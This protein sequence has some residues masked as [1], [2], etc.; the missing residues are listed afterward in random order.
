MRYLTTNHTMKKGFS[1]FLLIVFSFSLFAQS[2]DQLIE[3]SQS[4]IEKNHWERAYRNLNELIDSYEDEMTYLQ[5][6]KVYNS[7]GYLNL[8]FM[9]PEEAELD[10][11]RAL[12]YHEEAG[13]PNEEAYAEALINTSMLYLEQVEFDLSRDY[14]KKALDILEKKDEYYV[15]YLI[16]RTKLARIYEEAGSYTL[17]LSIYDESYDKL[18]A[19]GN[20]LSPDFADIC[21]HKGRILTLTGNPIEGERFI[22]LS[23]TIYESLGT[24]YNVQRA[25]SLE[26]LALF[27][28]QMG[29][30]DE[31]ENLLLEVLA[32]KRSIPDEADILI[33]ETLNDLGVLYNQL[34]RFTKAEKMFSEVIKESEE[35]VGV[36]HPFY[37]TAKNNLGMLALSRGNYS[38]AKVILEEALQLY[39]ERFGPSHPYYANTLNNL[40][41]TARKLGNIDQAESYY[42]EVLKIDLKLFGEDHPNYATTL[43][44]IGI[45]LSASDREEGAGEFYEKALKIRKIALGVNHPSYGSALD[46]LG[47]HY[48]AVNELALAEES[49]RESIGIQ[50]NLIQ[51]LFPIMS[52]QEREQFYFQVR[53]KVERYHFIASQLLDENQDLAKHIFDFQ[54]KTKT[55][56]FNS[57]DKVRDIVADSKDEVLKERYKKWLSDKSLLASYYQMG[58]DELADLHINLEQVESDIESQELFLSQN[59]EAFEEALPHK[60]L[61]SEAIQKAVIDG[62]AVV[63]IIQV[64]EFGPLLKGRENI[65]GFTDNSS[66]LAIILDGEK[67]QHTFL[68]EKNKVDQEHLFASQNAQD[69][70]AQYW[71]PIIS[72]TKGAGWLRVVPDGL[73]HKVNPNQYQINKRTFVIDEQYV[74]Y[75][76]S[77]H[78]VVRSNKESFN[79]KFYHI[80]NP[81]LDA[82]RFS[83]LSEDSLTEEP[84]IESI[85]SHWKT[86]TY[87][88]ED[89]NEFRL[90]SAYNPT[91][92]HVSAPIFLESSKTFIE[93]KTAL[94]DASFNSGIFLSGVS[95][96]YK[97]YQKSIPSIPENDGVLTVSEIMKLE[98]ERTR[99]VF[100]SSV[101]LE[102]AIIEG[103]DG[104]FGLIRA[105]SVAGARN[106]ITSI[107][108]VNETE[109]REFIEIFYQ[110]FKET[111]QIEASFRHA[112]LE[113]KERYNNPEIW[114]AFI[115][116]GSRL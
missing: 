97:K 98:L 18:I 24:N 66:Y 94:S 23:S 43:L 42:Y 81:D 110:R 35:N 90:R 99:L 38:E 32:L 95:D 104:F 84:S 83:Q 21:S 7:L 74:S 17:A 82:F 100:L 1:L 101:E 69:S 60:N 46:Y 64:R 103:G 48:L 34:G 13:I 63:E 50:L 59:I 86:V 116:L 53:E 44:N 85:F 62:E 71:E 5:K 9:D 31:A 108:E 52:E 89:A 6:A 27:Y 87:Q 12:L 40:A 70:F 80:Q 68:G 4:D 107:S 41:R 102:K 19:L 115:V 54:A 16:A 33:I 96:S 56:L 37:A 45:L 67:I 2:F 73:F 78:D 39:K 93:D 49:F 58:V 22:N 15:D 8:M 111:D 57:L 79:N 26:D 113:M 72:K 14:V 75:L 109:K 114:G 92:L 10:L 106:V 61:N 91:I 88:N 65:F 77:A 28:E 29:R 112:Q 51:A 47:L 3:T 11:N 25:E 55:L 30:F 105:F 20:E 36:S 76:S